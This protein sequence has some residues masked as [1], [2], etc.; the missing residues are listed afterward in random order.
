MIACL[1][2]LA[3]CVCGRCRRL[4]LEHNLTCEL[5]HCQ[6]L[7]TQTPCTVQHMIATVAL[8]M[9]CSPAIAGV[10][11][12]KTQQTALPGQV[13]HCGLRLARSP[14]DDHMSMH[15]GEDVQPEASDA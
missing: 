1:V 10:C 8:T 12:H 9:T 11:S 7:H 15:A 3:H 13:D 14:G 4:S 6:P 2:Q 5:D